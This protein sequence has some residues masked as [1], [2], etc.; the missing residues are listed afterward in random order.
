MSSFWLRVSFRRR[1]MP[2][3]GRE[4]E[5][6][7]STISLWTCRTSPGRTGRGH[8]ISPPAPGTPHPNGGPLGTRRFIVTAAVCQP[9][10]DSPPDIEA[11]TAAAATF[12]IQ[13]IGPPGIPEGEIQ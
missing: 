8:V 13:I 3:S 12:G 5:G 1:T 6:R 10:A 7:I 2:R 4:R 9:P 11:M